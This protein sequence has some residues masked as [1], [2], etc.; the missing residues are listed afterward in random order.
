M[1]NKFA[2]FILTHGRASNIRTYDSLRA[3]GYTGQIY[4][5]V[6]DLDSSL[7]EYKERYGDEVIVFDKQKAVDNTDACDN[8]GLHNSVV[9]A[10]NEN[11][12]I[13]KRLGITHF[14]QLD[15]DYTHWR[16]TFTGQGEYL[17]RAVAI[18]NLDDVLKVG[19]EALEAM[20]AKC[21]CFAQGGDFIG[22][23]G[24][25]VA[26]T[27]LRKNWFHRKAMNTFIFR[28]DNPV[29]FR[30]RGN[31]DVNTYVECGRRGDLF[32]TL[33][34]VRIEQPQTQKQAGGLTEMYLQFGTYVK[35]FYSVIVAPSC[36]K[37]GT[38]G[39]KPRIHHMVQWKYAVPKIIHERFRKK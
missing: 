10:R 22:G 5:L 28:T 14:I 16:W 29:A 32:V 23:S 21:V 30:G 1:K 18:T 25:G 20:K 34:Q 33:P 19:V 7:S 24:S 39:L 2:A 17:N 36:V 37:I 26:S 3:A 13:A 15:D 31:D 11:F 12:K 6:D 8:F 38:M 9:F 35:S 4:L 27:F